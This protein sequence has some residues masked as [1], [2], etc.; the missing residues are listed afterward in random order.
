LETAVS[1]TVIVIARKLKKVS[2]FFTS[3]KRPAI[4][5]CTDFHIRQDSWVQKG[6]CERKK[7][8]SNIRI[9]Y[10][11]PNITLIVKELISSNVTK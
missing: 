5:C 7:N 1:P 6:L 8:V 11:Y 10:H 9:N 3:A 4:A 2:M